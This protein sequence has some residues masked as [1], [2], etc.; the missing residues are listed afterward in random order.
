M[1]HRGPI[2]GPRPLPDP[3]GPGEVEALLLDARRE[4]KSGIHPEKLWQRWLFR[5]T[6]TNPAWTER[7]LQNIFEKLIINDRDY[8][9]LNLW[10]QYHNPRPPELDP[11]EEFAFEESKQRASA[12]CKQVME[13]LGCSY[14][15]A[16][17]IMTSG[18]AKPAQAKKLATGIKG[19]TEED[20]LRKALP[21]GRKPPSAAP[22]VKA[23]RIDGCS[24][25][26]FIESVA[27]GSKLERMSEA[28]AWLKEA[29]YSDFPPD[30]HFES[31]GDFKKAMPSVIHSTDAENVWDRYKVWRASRIIEAVEADLLDP[32]S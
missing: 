9:Y 21:R 2:A 10:N 24:L 26:D 17:T 20:W 4:I 25:F 18:T 8:T 19:T 32:R 7:K 3:N 14:P 31:M 11:F 1:K 28:V 16:Y 27:K 13:I 22:A 23:L 15:R 6:V 12:Q 29:Y 5:N 30:R